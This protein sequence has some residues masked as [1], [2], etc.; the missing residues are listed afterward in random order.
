[1]VKYEKTS[2]LKESYYLIKLIDPATHS[3]DQQFLIYTRIPIDAIRLAISANTKYSLS[4]IQCDKMP[5]NWCE[6][7]SL[8]NVCCKL[9]RIQ[10]YDFEDV[11]KTKIITYTERTIINL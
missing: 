2:K 11:V 4:I 8:E 1:M 3:E 5:S 6:A 7:L 10:C 9:S